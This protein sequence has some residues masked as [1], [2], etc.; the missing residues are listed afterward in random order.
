MEDLID[1]DFGDI[2][3]DVEVQA[4]SAINS[5]S[6]FA[7]LYTEP[8]EEEEE[9]NN[10]VTTREVNRSPD[11]GIL[12]SDLKQL[13]SI[14]EKSN[15]SEAGGSDS[16]DDLNIVLNDEDCKGFPVAAE[17]NDCCDGFEEGKDEDDDGFCS[18]KRSHDKNGLHSSANWLGSDH[19]N[20]VKGGYNSQY[21]QYKVLNL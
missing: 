8:Q 3:A 6:N 19:G 13:S 4:S 2:Y 10:K 18:I 9:C 12:K 7:K 21:P 5:I 14:C 15:I 1:D 11:E 20:G 17:R 16:E